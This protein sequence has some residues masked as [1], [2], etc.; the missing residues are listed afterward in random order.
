[1]AISFFYSTSFHT[2]R[3]DKDE[4]RPVVGIRAY[5]EQHR[6]VAFHCDFDISD[7]AKVRKEL[8]CSIQ[9][10]GERLASLDP[11]RFYYLDESQR[12]A[13]EEELLYTF[14]IL[15]A[16]YQLHLAES[17][18]YQI[19][20]R[21]KQLQRC[22]NLLN[23]FHAT[24]KA[25][26]NLSCEQSL[27]NAI[28]DSPD[29]PAAYI[30]LK[31]IAP[32]IAETMIGLTMSDYF[33]SLKKVM[34]DANVY[35]LNW[36]WGGG[37]DHILLDLIPL[38]FERSEQARNV[39]DHIAPVTGYM[40]WVL[41]YLRLGIELYLLAKYTFK[42]SCL[43][44][45][46]SSDHDNESMQLSI[47]MRFQAQWEMRKFNLLN[48]AFW[49]TANLACFFWLMGGGIYG[50]LGDVLTGVLLIFDLTLVAWGY[51]EK[52][53]DY[54]ALLVKYDEDIEA[55]E[56]TIEAETNDIAKQVLQQHLTVLQEAR[57]AWRFDWEYDER[58]WMQD[59]YYSIGLFASFSI[60]CCFFIPPAALLPATVLILGI[61]GAALSFLVTI[62]IHVWTTSTELEKLQKDY[63]ENLETLEELQFK[64]EKM[65]D[66]EQSSQLLDLELHALQ[67]QVAY[68]KEM[69]PYHKKM[70]IQQALSEALVPATAFSILIF[71]P[72]SY[73]L[74]V[75]IPVVGL[76][77][78]SGQ[79]LEW[80]SK[81]Q[82]PELPDDGLTQCLPSP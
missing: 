22:A 7:I 52:K 70:I 16:D 5:V 2:R 10:Y 51:Q 42:G 62:G 28:D 46:V 48:D 4:H 61:T 76:L 12:R 35:R 43:D 21:C 39:F 78:M 41:Y 18:N 72:L 25:G 40:S 81:P 45:W 55:L 29:K 58:Q 44:P 13:C 15:S 11:V 74:L 73:G 37:L 68:Q 8:Q 53:A 50:Y 69:I 65:P 6:N 23:T 54:A 36:V 19:K 47:G 1:M 20:K 32:E 64:R 75:L 24:P 38:D 77:M 63:D 17:N 60:L 26:E 33:F 67:K 80:T 31:I 9:F 34:S 57:D 56:K 49:A 82:E 3:P 59:I 30:A 79:L 66:L 71:M 14:Y 27:Q